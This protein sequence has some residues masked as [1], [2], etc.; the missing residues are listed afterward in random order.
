MQAHPTPGA[1]KKTPQERL[2]TDE[3]TRSLCATIVD[4]GW[5]GF[6]PRDLLQR[7]RTCCSLKPPSRHIHRRC[8]LSTLT[9]IQDAWQ[10]ARFATRVVWLGLLAAALLWLRLLVM[11]GL[12]TLP[13]MLILSG[14]FLAWG[15]S[16]AAIVLFVRGS[17]EFWRQRECPSLKTRS[18][19]Q[20]FVLMGLGLSVPMVYLLLR[21][22]HPGQVVL[23]LCGL[24][25]AGLGWWH[26][27]QPPPARL[28]ALLH[29]LF[30]I[31]LFNIPREAG[32]FNL[33]WSQKYYS[34]SWNWNSHRSHTGRNLNGLSG[35]I[36]A[37][38]PRSQFRRVDIDGAL[39]AHLTRLLPKATPRHTRGKALFT[40]TGITSDPS[41]PCY[42]PGYR[43]QAFSGT[44]YLKASFQRTGRHRNNIPWRLNAYE[45]HTLN[46]R[47]QASL[48]G[49]GSC[50]NLTRYASQQL[51][52]RLRR[53]LRN[54]TGRR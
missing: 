36:A 28:H 42:I 3:H 40:L 4:L 38:R 5:D 31:L 24:A 44:L 33:H 30:L 9:K 23:L 8:R 7:E 46:F 1:T 41:L 53:K 16:L 48:T 34:A 27:R 22:E 13:V 39:G 49:I 32:I 29:L 43:S 50:Y 19:R 10:A 37:H 20:L 21:A 17:W 51:A 47:I 35:K 26:R 11:A 15:C 45:S 54:I 12:Y 6:G 52:N 25:T 18:V 14:L 2:P